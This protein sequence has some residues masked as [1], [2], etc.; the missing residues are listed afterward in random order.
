MQKINPQNYD[1]ALKESFS[2]FENKTLDFLG[3][4]LPKITGFLETEIEDPYSCS[5]TLIWIS[6]NQII[7]YG[8]NPIHD[9]T[10]NT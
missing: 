5:Y 7:R 1:L 10:D 4:D 6:G 8:N 9:T 3:L 2:I